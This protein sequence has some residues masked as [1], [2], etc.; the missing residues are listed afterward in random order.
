M[1]TRRTYRLRGQ[2]DLAEDSARR[3]DPRPS[4]EALAD[5]DRRL[6]YI[7][8]VHMAVLGDPPPG[9][10]ALDGWVPRGVAACGF[11]ERW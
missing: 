1:R 6:N 11:R 8:T 5:R 4:A 2:H 7:E 3:A 9:R 10:S